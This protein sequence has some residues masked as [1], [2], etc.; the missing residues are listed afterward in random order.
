MRWRLLVDAAQQGDRATFDQVVDLDQVIDN[1]IAQS[2][3]GSA[4]G[5]PTQSVASV[6]TRLQ[7]LAPETSTS[8]KTAVREEIQKRTS[9]L[10]GS[11]AARPFFVTALGTPFRERYQANGDIAHVKD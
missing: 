1:F 10:A 6:R 3:P 8:I 7:S 4:L 2:A 11:T 5:S 9:E